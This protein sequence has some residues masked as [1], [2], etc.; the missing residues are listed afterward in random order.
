MEEANEQFEFTE[1]YYQFPKMIN[2]RDK[3]NYDDNLVMI[4]E[5]PLG[6]CQTFTIAR[7]Y[8][9]DDLNQKEIIYL[10]IKIYKKLGR[11]QMIIDLKDECNKSILKALECITKA[12]YTTPYI[13]T[14]GN[15]MN[16]H[17][18]QLDTIKLEQ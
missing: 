1:L 17:I 6:N 8:K 15:H 5:S 11:P 13:S 14:N 12:I 16:L 4:S 9:L 7:A 18:I 2:V 3:D 10:F